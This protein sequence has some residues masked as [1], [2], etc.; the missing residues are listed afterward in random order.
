MRGRK[1]GA[2]PVT[3]ADRPPASRQFDV[4]HW[5]VAQ[6]DIWRREQM[7]ETHQQQL[8]SA[9]ERAHDAYYRAEV[10]GGPSLY[11]HLRSLEAA[12]AKEFDR[13]AEYV[14]AV[15]ASW[16]M[17]RMGPGGSKMRDFSEFQD[18]LRSVWPAALQ[19]QAMT[20]AELDGSGWTSLRTIFCGIR[21]MASGTS[22]VGNSKV[23]AHLLPNLVPPV[24]RQYTLKF[25]FGYGQIINGIEGE[26]KKLMQILQGFFY[27]LAQ[28]P[29]FQSKANEW[30]SHGDKYRWDTSHLK[31]VDNLV[32]GLS[33]L[34][35]AEQAA[36]GGASQAARP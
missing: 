31:I 28:S 8:L 5:P 9:L 18:S 7:F 13:F 1:R 16:G 11:F 2:Q 3:G 35:R 33:K 4:Q 23:M 29:L 10:F 6:H 36:P 25:L 12:R 22:L 26:W 27:P 32:I 24:D 34:V 17:H 19:L 21:C 15:L 14:Y 30:L 20:L